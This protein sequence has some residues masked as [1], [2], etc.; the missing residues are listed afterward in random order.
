MFPF[1]IMKDIIVWLLKGYIFKREAGAKFDKPKNYRKYLNSSNTG[2]VLDGDN[3]AL[4][5]QD[6]F[7]NVCVIARI[8]AGKTSRYIIPNV[9]NRAK[10]HCS[11]VV[12]DPKGEVFQATSAT[13]EAWGYRILV[14][15]PENPEYS[16]Y[17]N[18]LAE[19]RNDIELDQIAE[20]IVKA[21][22]PRDKDEFWNQGAIRFVSF[23]LRCLAIAEEDEPG[24]NN[25]AN[26]Y[27]LLQNFGADG[28]KLDSWIARNTVIP[29]DPNDQVLWNEWNGL[30]TGNKEGI[31]SFV[32]NALTALKA[33][34]NRSIAQVT[35]RSDFSLES[36]RKQKTALF[37]ITPPQLAGYYGFLISVFFRSVFNAS[38]RERPDRSTL[39]LY[40]FYDEFGHSTIPNFVSTAN[41][42]RAYRVSL[43][44][45]LQSI[46]QLSSRYGRDEGEAIKGGFSTYLSYAGSDPET[47]RFFELICGRKRI[48]QLPSD[49]KN[50]T[51]HYREENLINSAEIRMMS[52]DEVLIVSANRQPVKI[53][54]TPYFKNMRLK[55]FTY[56]D[57]IKIIRRPLFPMKYTKI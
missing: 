41:T 5:E 33:L 12:N 37:F 55:K 19:A 47:T 49:L 22:N 42:I 50:F 18:P 17:F 9:L 48:T 7:Q 57:P 4:S 40:I 36:I 24:V 3:L 23:F 10:R 29:D 54:S 20:I 46:T 52:D 35:S 26:L 25:L 8:G 38:M 28:N 16:A 56:K 43:S 13:L 53:T 31:Q 44:I 6:S 34:S 45:V 39:P 1:N 14:I 2:L 51:E 30:L 21:G 32:L 27:Y 11:L 15:S